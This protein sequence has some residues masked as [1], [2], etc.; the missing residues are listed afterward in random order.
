MNACSYATN[1]RIYTLVVMLRITRF[2]RVSEKVKKDALKKKCK[3]EFG[4]KNQSWLP[5]HF[6]FMIT[7]S[8]FGYKLWL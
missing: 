4:F 1:C 2:K 6:N 8:D 5:K 7:W 3:C